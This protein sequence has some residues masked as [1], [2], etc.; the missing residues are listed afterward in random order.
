[1]TNKATAKLGFST[2]IVSLTRE[3][4]D[5]IH[6]ATLSSDDARQL[7]LDLSMLAEQLDKRRLVIDGK[8][9][10]WT[11]EYTQHAEPL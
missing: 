2:V 10:D 4:G 9:T 7:A 8:Q 11:P 6:V 5:L 1:M 3:N